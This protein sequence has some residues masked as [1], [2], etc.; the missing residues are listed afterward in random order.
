ML[1]ISSTKRSVKK[2]FYPQTS[3]ARLR[4]FDLQEARRFGH[5]IGLY[6]STNLSAVAYQPDTAKCDSIYKWA[7]Y[8]IL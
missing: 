6:H 4:F 8:R 3:P 2:S 5:H 1:R 7:S